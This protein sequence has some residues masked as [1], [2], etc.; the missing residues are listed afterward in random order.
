M[1]RME[2]LLTRTH[3]YVAQLAL[4]LRGPAGLGPSSAHTLPAPSPGAPPTR[5]GTQAP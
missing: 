4:A 1:E 5:Y 3:C 2:I